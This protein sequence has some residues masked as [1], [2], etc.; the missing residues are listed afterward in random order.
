M[1]RII[2][3]VMATQSQFIG[4]SDNDDDDKP[5]GDV[6][7]NQ[8]VVENIIL[9]IISGSIT[10]MLCFIWVQV[11]KKVQ[12]KDKGILLMIFSLILQMVSNVLW[13]LWDARLK[14]NDN[15][16]DEMPRSFFDLYEVLLLAPLSFYLIAV[17][18]NINNW[19]FYYFKI[20]EM[21]RL[22]DP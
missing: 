13:Y 15:N 19:I 9:A 17:I 8:I 4:D 20:G 21:A 1:K 3:K 2:L 7:C 18:L 12:W 10:V 22:V 11:F 5:C 16:Y 14:R 6:S